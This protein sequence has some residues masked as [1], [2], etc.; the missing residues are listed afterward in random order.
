ME[1]GGNI[2][3]N[4]FGK[5]YKEAESI[6][7]DASKGA[8]DF[9]S[10]K[11]NT[12]YGKDGGK[13]FGDYEEKKEEQEEIAF[14][15]WWS[16]DYEG[17]RNLEKDSRGPK[18]SLGKTVYYHLIVSKDIPVGTSI[19][20][21]LWDKDT[22]MFLDF[23][24]PDDYKFGG[25]KVYRTATVR[26]VNGKHQ[27]T[28]ELFL[29]PNWNSDLVSDM[30]GY[31][32]DGCLD[33][34]WTW[35]YNKKP[36]TSNTNLLSVYP[37][38]T[39]L[40]IKPAINNRNYGLPEIYSNSGLVILYAIEKLP[41][42]TIKHFTMLKLRTTT[43]FRFFADINKFKKEIYE[44]VINLDTNRLTS[45]SYAVEDGITIFKTN[46]NVSQIFIDEHMV[47]V[48]IE[49]RGQMVI[50]NFKFKT[51]KFAKVAAKAYGHYI[52]LSEMKEMIPMLSSNDKFNMPS[53]ST[54]VGFIPQLEVVAFGVAV[55]GWMV[56]GSL[57]EVD[58]IVDESMWA[59]WQ[60][61]KGKGLKYAQDFMRNSWGREKLFRSFS[62]SKET[63]DKLLKGNFKTLKELEN[64]NNQ[65]RSNKNNTIIIYDILDLNIR[66]NI[67]ILDS[68]FINDQN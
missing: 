18:S 8:L 39:T 46:K 20:F 4:I 33:F 66:K 12:F 53:L 62:V 56:A 63:L 38:E 1:E 7:K 22:L 30:K 35:E 29:N 32:K 45:A 28:I 64:F 55:V 67:T 26:E 27:I 43:T 24:V 10:P 37:S 23:L 68:I 6:T 17:I 50:N 19:T 25:K 36:W 3:R 49:G 5:S 2:I 59:D 65:D 52:V 51:V 57:K 44:E 54:F 13:K 60:N 41:N 58:E 15:G 42:G 47:E 61:A 9:K 14:S 48:P 34:Y 31:F 16:P 11:E 21:Q 40:Y